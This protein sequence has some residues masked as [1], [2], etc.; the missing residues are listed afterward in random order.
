MIMALITKVNHHDQHFGRPQ[1]LL[2]AC[3]IILILCRSSLSDAL[4]E[5]EILLKFKASLSI[6][7]ALSNWNDSK[8]PC[9]TGNWAGVYCLNNTVWGL[10]LEDIG[11]KGNL[12]VEMLKELRGLRTISVMW[13]DLEGDLPHFRAVSSLKAVY[14]SYNNFSGEIKADAFLGM[15]SLKR[16]HAAHNQFTGQIPVSLSVLP[17]LMDLRLENNRFRG[18]IPNFQQKNLKFFNVSNNELEGPIPDNLINLSATSFGGNTNLCGGPLG[19]C[20]I[21]VS[22]LSVAIIVLS[23]VAAVAALAAI[24][25]AFVI[26]GQ[27]R[28]PSTQHEHATNVTGPTIT[29]MPEANKKPMASTAIT[30]LD[31][32]EQGRSHVAA[33]TTT[34]K[35]SI[36][37]SNGVQ[38]SMKLTFVREDCPKFNLSD[39]LRASA[40]ILG[41]G[42]FGSTY[43]ADLRD[44]S[45]RVGKLRPSAVVVKRYRKMNNVGRE[46]FQEHM[47]RL[48]KF[49]HPNLLPLVAYY[50]RKEEKL[51][52]SDYVAKGSL[53]FHLHG[54]S[55]SLGWGKR[56]RIVKGVARGLLYLYKELHSLVA[57]HGH[58]KSANVV[59]TE[60]WE[61][62]LTD[63]ALTPIVNQ[64]DV[65]DLMIVYKSPEYKQLGRITKKTDIWTLGILILEI[66]TG[67]FPANTIQP[68]KG[69]KESVD[70]GT[71]VETLV[72]EDENWKDKVF[73]KDMMMNIKGK[74][75]EQ[76]MIK[77]LKI[78]L[79]CCEIDVEARLDINEA[80]ERIENVREPDHNSVVCNDHHHGD[81]AS[82]DEDFY[83]SYASEGDMR[84]CRGLSDDFS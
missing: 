57:P 36:S 83:S 24:V 55:N 27:R 43:K 64:E 70:S 19:S 35:R 45:S 11:L 53:A 3:A 74:E 67:R 75:E 29:S 66:L 20:K 7:N 13:N 4:S 69:A 82:K 22:K 8:P 34:Y 84:S 48:G 1:G 80:V 17:R 30:D 21:M 38:N 18:E 50:Y 68:G 37:K 71:W 39:L 81:G 32:I 63:Y 49:R 9:P 16:F 79:A 33:G 73:D 28:Q 15:F 5:S 59:L 41:S 46:D 77:L 62:V 56:L 23:V 47:R 6:N 44:G 58:L 31:S 76:E 72:K 40:E 42:I 65:Q 14:V 52:V 51:M 12:K 78:G 26:L 54:G 10:K 25:V 2:I 60:A 61:P